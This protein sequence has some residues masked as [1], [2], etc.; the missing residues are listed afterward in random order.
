M[1][2]LY[3]TVLSTYYG[4][5]FVLS[6][7]NFL[8]D[9]DMQ[10]CA[11]GV[12]GHKTALTENVITRTYNR[13]YQ[14]MNTKPQWEDETPVP[15][16]PKHSSH[17]D[18]NNVKHHRHIDK[19]RLERQPLSSY[20]PDKLPC[21]VNLTLNELYTKDKARYLYSN[22]QKKSFTA[23]EDFQPTPLSKY[24][25]PH[26]YYEMKRSRDIICGESMF[27]T[28]QK[29]A[30]EFKRH[31]GQKSYSTLTERSWKKR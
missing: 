26:N 17:P 4:E 1:Q 27:K 19:K 30:T 20:P 7:H 21:K 8:Q 10:A 12:I 31:D 25:K 16:P 18:G 23:A 28:R 15:K 3:L 11:Q 24:Q 9:L 2:L 13:L 5:E 14:P 22:D 6:I 29:E